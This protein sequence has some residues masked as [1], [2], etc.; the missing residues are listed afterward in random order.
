MFVLFF[1]FGDEFNKEVEELMKFYK[2]SN[3]VILKKCME[4]YKVFLGRGV[5]GCGCFS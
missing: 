4:F 5:C 2:F 1:L 3:K